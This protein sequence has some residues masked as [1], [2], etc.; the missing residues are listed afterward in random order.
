MCLGTRKLIGT[1]GII[2]FV[3]VYALV[4]MTLAQAH[5]VQDAAVLMQVLCAMR[6]PAWP[7]SCR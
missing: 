2:G 5:Q 1:S 6:P 4:A 3:P 7:G